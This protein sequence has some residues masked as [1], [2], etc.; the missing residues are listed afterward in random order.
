MSYQQCTRFWTTVDFDRECLCNRSSNRQAENS[1]SNY[2]YFPRSGKT[3][4]WTL[5][6][7]R[8]NDLNL[9]PMTYKC[10]S[11]LEMHVR[12]KFH[13][14]KCNGSW[15]IKRTE[16]QNSDENN[17]VR[18]YHAETNNE[19]IIST[20][21]DSVIWGGVQYLGYMV[22]VIWL[23]IAGLG[24]TGLSFPLRRRTDRQT[25]GQRDG[26]A[27]PVMRPVR[28]QHNTYEC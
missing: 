2:D 5:V 1:V 9:C 7:L 3:I 22:R 26:R 11:F 10:N 18:R 23:A 15:V 12:A 17:T 16:K 25:H 4:W 13:R 27:G 21:Y 19:K 20:V 8:N 28:R 6:H 24:Y 14:A